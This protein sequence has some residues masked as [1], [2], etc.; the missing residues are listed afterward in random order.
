MRQNK[1]RH[2]ALKGLSDVL[3][4]TLPPKKLKWTIKVSVIISLLPY[5]R[6]GGKEIMTNTFI[7]HL[8]FYWFFSTD[9]FAE[10]SEEKVFFKAIFKT[11]VP[12]TVKILLWHIFTF[13]YYLLCYYK[14]N[15]ILAQNNKNLTSPQP[16]TST[17]S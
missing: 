13:C 9:L 11:N 12:W 7:V 14:I 5:L 3:L 10:F 4:T 16:R 8:S 15:L 2:F 17:L 6:L 1:L